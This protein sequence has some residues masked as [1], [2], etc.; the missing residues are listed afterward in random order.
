MSHGLPAC[1]SPHPGLCAVRPPRAPTSPAPTPA[2]TAV[3]APAPRTGT[4]GSGKLTAHLSFPGTPRGSARFTDAQSA[5]RPRD[6]PFPPLPSPRAFI[7]AVAGACPGPASRPHF[8]HEG[9]RWTGWRAHSPRISRAQADRGSRGPT[10][11][12]QDGCEGHGRG[13]AGAPGSPRLPPSLPPCTTGTTGS[14][15]V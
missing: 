3:P 12:Q 9:P 8:C 5:K 11:G 13:G 7:T 14:A 10:H 6:A 2:P 15:G 4:C 1:R